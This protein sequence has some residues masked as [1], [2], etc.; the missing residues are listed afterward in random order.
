VLG[1]DWRGFGKVW[2]KK[3]EPR[4]LYI[5]AAAPKAERNLGG[6]VQDG[7]NQKRKEHCRRRERDTE[8]KGSRRISERSDVPIF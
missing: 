1:E 8:G 3:P 2:S 5:L 6:F 7:D 4:C